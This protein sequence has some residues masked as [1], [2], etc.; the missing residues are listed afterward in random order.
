MIGSIAL[1]HQ[2][3]KDPVVKARMHAM[4]TAGQATKVLGDMAKGSI[5]FDAD[6]AAEAKALLIQVARDLPET[7]KEN[8]SD[9]VSEARP[10]IWDDFADFTIRAEIMET[11]ATALDTSSAASIGAGMRAL[12][13]SCGGCHKAYRQKK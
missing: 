1:A 5:A 7:F 4:G 2:G 3:V 10:T 13:G 9:P 6:K 8:A 12:G 11:T